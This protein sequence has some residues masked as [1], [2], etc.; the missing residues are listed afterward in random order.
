MQRGAAD[1]DELNC[2]L[3]EALN[4]DRD[5]LMRGETDPLAARQGHADS[6]QL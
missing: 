4:P 6:Q 1:A 5:E 2:V 3:Q